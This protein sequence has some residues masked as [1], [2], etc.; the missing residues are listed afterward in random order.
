MKYTSVYINSTSSTCSD[1]K[2]CYY[3]QFYQYIVNDEA[4]SILEVFRTLNS[5]NFEDYFI[6]FF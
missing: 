2:I 3:F 5:R 1:A 6:G 4:A